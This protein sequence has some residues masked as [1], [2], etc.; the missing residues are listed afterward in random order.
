MEERL[1]RVDEERAHIDAFDQDRK[2]R[3][4]QLTP[5]QRIAALVDE[6]SFL[7]IGAFAKS[8]H[9]EAAAETPADGVITG[10]AKSVGGGLLSWPRIQWRSR[11]PTHRLARASETA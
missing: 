2:L 7:E 10:Y 6:G 1:Q 3:P 4:G 5:R 8:Q 9:R 11:A